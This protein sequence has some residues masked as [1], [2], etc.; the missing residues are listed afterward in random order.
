MSLGDVTGLW[1][2]THALTFPETTA[3]MKSLHPL[4][5]ALSLALTVLCAPAAAQPDMSPFRLGDHLY[6]P[7]ADI[8][9]PHYAIRLSLA[10]PKGLAAQQRF[11]VLFEADRE[12]N[13]YRLEAA[14]GQWSLRRVS[15]RD[16]ELIARGR[17]DV[18]PTAEPVEICITRRLPLLSVALNRE[19]VAEILGA[20][21]GRGLMAVDATSS[22]PAADPLI[23]PLEDLNFAEGFM[24][25]EEELD[26]A[27]SKVWHLER[28]D[29]RLHSVQENVEIVDVERLPEGR[30][31][32]TE[33]SPNP[34]SVSGR[35]PD[36]G[37]LWAGEWFWGDYQATLSVRN[38]G[39]RAV[40]LAF[41]IVDAG[42]YFLLRWENATPL[43]EAT[44]V[45]LLHVRG[46]QRERLGR[47]W[48]N[49]QL[50]QWFSL[51]VRTCG[52]RVQAILDGAVIMDLTSSRLIGGGVGLY[53]EG[54]DEE[55]QAFFDDV[56]VRNT[57]VIDY[58][59]RTW[60]ETHARRASGSWGV[61][62][63]ERPARPPALAPV[64]RSRSGELL[65]GSV[66]WPAP[67]LRA[68]V[69]V[70]DGREQVGF[71][72]G[73][74][75]PGEQHW[76]VTL[77]RAGDA[78]AL[79]IVEEGEAG[80]R[81]LA[82][83]EDVPLPD[84]ESVELCVDFTREGEI[85]VSVDGRLWLRAPRTGSAAGAP[86][87]FG[88]GAKGAEFRD[89]AVCFE[90]QEDRERL[91][92]EEVFKD[93]PYMK[94]WSSPQGAWWPETGRADA[95][96]HVGDFYGRSDIEIPL[97]AG[98]LFV[99]AAHTIAQDGGY[100]LRQ[101]ELPAEGEQRRHELALLRL[102]R[103]VAAATVDP[104]SVPDGKVVLH[105]HGPYV[106]VTAGQTELLSF[107]DPEPLPGTRAAVSG[108][109]AG[110]LANLTIHRYQVQDYYFERAP[111]DWYAVGR[112]EVTARFTCDPRW[113]HMAAV[114]D[115]AA[116]LFNKFRYEGDVTLEAFM[117]MRM[118]A[119]GG[120]YP[121]VGDLNL[122]LYTRPYDLSSGYS[123]V[124][125][126]WDP[127]WSE[128]A[129]YLLKGTERVAFCGERLLP[130]VRKPGEANRVIPVPW[131]SGG[132][133]IHGAWYYV[134]A[135]K[136]GNRL[137]FYVDNRLAYEYEDPEPIE[138]FS[139]AIWTYDGSVVFAR[140]KVSYERKRVPGRLVPAPAETPAPAQLPTAPL[141]ASPTH[142][143]FRDDFE[144][145]A[146]EWKTLGGPHGGEPRV[147]PRGQ[148]GHCL[149]VTNA[150]AGGTFAVAAPIGELG[151]DATRVAKVRFDYRIPLDTKIN[152]YL[153]IAGA[154]HFVRLTGPR[155]SSPML[156]RLGEVQVEA[157]GGWHS[158]EF[159][160]GAAYLA[161]HPDA[162]AGSA[163]IE[164]IAFGNLH[165]GLLAAGIGGN[166][167][168][169]S[170]WIDDFQV[171]S[172]APGRFQ[173]EAKGI[174][175]VVGEWLTA[176][177][178]RPDTT[179]EEPGPAS[180]D[181]LGP[182]LWHW[183][184]RGRLADGTLTGTA[185]L[186]LF[187]A[188]PRLEAKAAS[189]PD[190]GQWGYGPIVL[191]LA[192]GSALHLDT[193]RLGL[194]VNG[195][196]V[197][198]YE[199]LFTVDR[200]ADT[201][202]IDLGRGGVSVG[203]GEPCALELSYPN[204]DGTSGL[205]RAQYVGSLKDDV[206]PPGPV[207][208]AGV[209]EPNGFEEG[210]G[211]WN[212]AQNLHV[213]RD[214]ST[215]ATG[216]WSLMV[217][218]P[219]W[220]SPFT[221]FAISNPFS[222]G[223]FAIVDFDYKIHDA[224]M[225][226]FAV[227]NPLGMCT[228]GFTDRSG[229]A[230]YLGPI[231]GVQADDQWHHAELNLLRLLKSLPYVPGIFQQQWLCLRDFGYMAG[232]PGASYHLDNFRLVTPISPRVQP[233]IEWQAHDA[234]GIAGYSY[235]WSARPDAEPDETIDAEHGRVALKDVPEPHA[236]LHVKA[237]DMAGNWGPTARYRFLVDSTAPRVL[238]PDPAPDARSASSFVAFT[239]QEDVSAVDPET[240]RVEIDGR[241]YSPRSK[242][243]SY[244]L[245]SGR[246]TWDWVA[247]APPQQPCIPDGSVVRVRVEA[248]DF[249]GNAAEPLAWQWV[250][251]YSLDHTP[252]TVPALACKTMPVAHRDGFEAEA[253]SWENPRGDVWG[254]KV[255][256]VLRE[257]AADD[258]CL[259]L[260]AQRARSYL[261]ARAFNG[262]CDLDK[263]PIVS[264]DYL[265]PAGTRFNLQA[266]VNG[267]WYEVQLTSPNTQRRSL[268]KVEGIQADGEWHHCAIDLLERVRGVL[269][270]ARELKLTQLVFLDPARQ[271]RG[272]AYWLVDNFVIAGYGEPQ[273][274]FAW[275][276]RDVTG[277]AGYSVRFDRDP[278]AVPDEEVDTTEDAGTFTATQSG[279]YYL[280]VR[281]LDHGGNWSSVARLPY[282]VKLAPP[283]EA[284]AAP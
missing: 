129:T 271:N 91:P 134:K 284:P 87:V 46:N 153:D 151:L 92:A 221:T 152:L 215:A 73:L 9:A 103:Q 239:V 112:W 70:P 61:T 157:D 33:R 158:A 24:R 184:V 225:V 56:V 59:N 177:D 11:C 39:A 188:P 53:V 55:H 245:A 191:A 65:L 121:R 85:N 126:G 241:T 194:K 41:N 227:A 282:F 208:V 97:R 155:D 214:D 248:S 210:L 86:A 264:F 81:R 7:V 96:W 263:H 182:G 176:L 71:V 254:A 218:N 90:R 69:P 258:H 231:E 42:D 120:G 223:R 146:G 266:L 94:H 3:R 180:A 27:K 105:R 235:V 242:G 246:F 273:A 226:D 58:T 51:G 64:L 119:G 31:P 4:A 98:V 108:L 275:R 219:A 44:P 106:W 173:A 100:A 237:R 102:G 196:Q 18:L 137:S 40:G 255:Q 163:R 216:R 128:R 19:V 117:G 22:A 25:T 141:V 133:D 74:G 247:G 172:S 68:E 205:L 21:H 161:S 2:A 1:R 276:S 203:D 101:R 181:D 14:E 243:V 43:L 259:K 67:C 202:A 104:A 36:W 281:A 20:P 140:V 110:E 6:V 156:R 45:E 167:T 72:A 144:A 127:Y 83:C 54:G 89:L 15:G 78:L 139:P 251:D 217:Q 114:T 209:P 8:Q 224:V 253:V 229:E 12:G 165:P 171:Y 252:P 190:G 206:T 169:A 138:A 142:P 82:A 164:R 272:N 277:I 35:A 232:A 66:E 174:D 37:L 256:R 283:P 34:F 175:G 233:S 28:G 75:G 269:P 93:D 274:Q 199:G 150:G 13:G 230:R 212:A 189:P 236:Y 179:P 143:G 107:R 186:P 265:I 118:H 79:Q 244:E 238:A 234:G 268:G 168:G 52:T 148:A 279:T 60:I 23:Q 125:A 48:V 200:S 207:V 192:P 95:F 250:M 260:S 160:L 62:E 130:S 170:Y 30:R 84:G 166:P 124:L 187:V 135:R 162:R 77:G 195:R 116:I 26:L 10:P 145:G 38:R 49:G 261:S 240:L 197:E 222:A 113:S 198:P 154:R 57:S 249:A 123:F 201:L 29:W 280:S 147:V 76:R 278:A 32:Q 16:E 270:S 99:H 132:R 211:T 122:A 5:V 262:S 131:I 178:H 88:V 47:A 17:Q 111:G 228:I 204:P 63:L 257:E 80:S 136:R 193:S 183:H 115:S 220:R 109:S 50:D 185:H 213:A 149:K 159:D 267:A